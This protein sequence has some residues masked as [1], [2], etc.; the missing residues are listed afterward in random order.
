MPHE[1]NINTLFLGNVVDVTPIHPILDCWW[2]PLIHLLLDVMNVKLSW[3]SPLKQNTSHVV[4]IYFVLHYPT[5]SYI[6]IRPGFFV[7]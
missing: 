2:V 6:H 4:L 5:I 7:R 3:E 1:K